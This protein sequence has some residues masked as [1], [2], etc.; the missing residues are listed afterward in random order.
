MKI[1]REGRERNVD[2]NEACYIGAMDSAIDL[3]LNSNLLMFKTAQVLI[4][5]FRTM[6][7][8]KEF[9]NLFKAQ[10]DSGRNWNVD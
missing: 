9:S 2:C 4:M 8:A 10:S 5:D 6:V 1:E 7:S 3:S